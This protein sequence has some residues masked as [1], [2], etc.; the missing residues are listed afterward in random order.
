MPR[1]VS[2]SFQGASAQDCDPGRP[3]FT[4]VLEDAI[5]DYN[6]T[7][8][9]LSGNNS[10]ALQ[11]THSGNGTGVALGLPSS[12][13]MTFIGAAG[14]AI[15]YRFDSVAIDKTKITADYVFLSAAF[16]NC[17]DTSA[18]RIGYDSSLYR[19]IGLARPDFYKAFCV[20]LD[21]GSS[22][23]I[24]ADDLLDLTDDGSLVFA[25]TR[26]GGTGIYLVGLAMPMQLAAAFL[27][28]V[29]APD[30]SPLRPAVCVWHNRTAKRT[31]M[32]YQR[33]LRKNNSPPQIQTTS[34]YGGSSA[35]AL[36]PLPWSDAVVDG[37]KFSAAHVHLLSRAQNAMAESLTG[38]PAGNDDGGLTLADHSSGTYRAFH[39][40]SA[41]TLK[42]SENAAAMPL[43]AE[44]LGI[45]TTDG[46]T[47]G[48][49]YAA[50]PNT[51]SVAG[52]VISTMAV[53]VPDVPTT[54]M[55]FLA[56][57]YKES[58]T[59]APTASIS[60]A[61][62]GAQA[63]TIARIGTS[64]FWT[65]SLTSPT[66][67]TRGAIN[68]VGLSVVNVTGGSTGIACWSGWVA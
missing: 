52:T 11:H 15:D 27:P 10:P 28:S 64:Q 13:R 14:S 16:I 42:T 43:F 1:L 66:S 5:G 38:A 33:K 12:A 31:D 46:E 41:P 19:G 25:T 32:V 9:F 60:V 44:S 62:G 17:I 29:V 61:G 58:G 34:T 18:I 47:V 68:R 54:T 65:A 39:D 4:R 8:D 36:T 24:D 35:I 55:R 30:V 7:D 63:M 50:P 56:L 21:Y 53:A 57:L 48:L 45:F 59:T 67:L 37:L 6:L 22:T 51:S 26:P 2:S 23:I 3:S 49:E 20:A 40:H